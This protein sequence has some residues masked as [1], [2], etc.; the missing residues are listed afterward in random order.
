MQVATL[1][2][3]L[4]TLVLAL[5]VG[6]Q[7]YSWASGDPDEGGMIAIVGAGDEFAAGRGPLET[8]RESDPTESIGNGD[9]EKKEVAEGERTGETEEGAAGEPKKDEKD[10]KDK[11]DGGKTKEAEKKRTLPELPKSLATIA[12]SGILGKAPVKQKPPPALIGFVGDAAIIRSPGG[13]EDLVRA[14]G[15]IDGVKV[16]EI[17]VNRVLIEYQ[18]KKLEL[19]VYAG[20]GGESLLPP[21]KAAP[22]AEKKASSPAKA[23][24]PEAAPTKESEA[25]Q[26]TAQPKKD[27]RA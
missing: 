1:I 22:E 13:R 25:A 21:K 5:V 4:L 10:K 26:P 17:G 20:Q 3:K 8:P 9:P 27:S 16:L 11:K 23:A 15:E 19:M 6:W 7:A 12:A 14:G 18:N 2:L 24:S